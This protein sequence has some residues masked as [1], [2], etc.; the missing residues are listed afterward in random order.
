MIDLQPFKYGAIAADPPWGFKNYS[1]KG[2]RKNA[3]QHY[4]CLP[5]EEIMAWSVG[6]LAK[7]DSALFLW[8]TG[9]ML[10]DALR[11]MEAWGFTYKAMAFVWA[12]RS[13]RDRAWHF[14]LGYWTRANAEICLLG[15]LG[16][17]KR[18]SAGVP[19]L[20]VAPVREHSRKPDE[21]YKRIERL[22][23]G[24]YLDLC[25]REIRPGWDAFGDEV[26]KFDHPAVEAESTDPISRR[27]VLLGK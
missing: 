12:K 5:T 10:P 13:S 27:T 24:P 23:A 15:T 4:R 26:G 25:S 20:I 8:A 6:H 1:A 2:E 9:P 16:R 3:N 19:Q 18:L 11:V 17:P 7:P 21:A 14:G 22:V